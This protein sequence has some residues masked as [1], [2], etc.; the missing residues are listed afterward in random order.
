MP[1]RPPLNAFLL[2]SAR[3]RDRTDIVRPSGEHLE[4]PER[5]IQFGTGAFLRGFVDY[6]LDCANH[7]GM[8]RGRIV[9]VGSTG[10]GRDAAFE[11]QDGLFTLASRGLQNGKSTE[12]LRIVGAVSRALSANDDWEAVL[13]VARSPDL[14]LIFSNTTE[15]GIAYDEGD[16]ADMRP[17][18]SFPA[19][20][21]RFLLERARSFEFDAAWSVV[22]LPCELIEDNGDRLR[23]MVVRH[24]RRWYVE[25]EFFR[26]LDAAVPFCNTLVDRIVP[27]APGGA[28]RASL[29]ERLGYSDALLTAC[30]PYRLFA[31]ETPAHVPEALRFADADPGIV[32][33]EDIAPFRERKVRLLN[34]AHTLMV[35]VALGIGA[36]TV[37]DAVQ[38]PAVG[39]FVRSAMQEEIAPYLE[40]PG[41]SQFASE[42]LER[43]ANPHVHHLLADITLQATMKMRVRVLPSIRRYAEATGGVPRALA[44]GYAAHLWF[45]GGAAAG[46]PETGRADEQGGSIRALWTRHASEGDEGVRAMALAASSNVALWDSD[47]SRIPGFVDVVADHLIRIR[48][49][50][51]AAALHASTAT[52]P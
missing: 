23:E 41:A 13:E 2:E 38:H 39:A 45:A 29:E 27:G 19:K 22:V 17:P 9:A 5:A 31:I 24:G 35:P 47:L 16:T 7:R 8:F 18:R 46:A 32:L 15:V 43:F 44:F 48:T 20:L 26:W 36:E 40:A 6:F 28:A 14:E 30:E 21:A 50:G 34:G 49:E 11:Q 25:P 10:S 33:A 12:S 1:S 42:V 52:V 4:Y 51:M 3:L 37:R